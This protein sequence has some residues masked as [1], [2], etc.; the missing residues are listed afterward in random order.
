M[1]TDFGAGIFSFVTFLCR[2]KRPVN[3]N[4]A[5]FGLTDFAMPNVS[6]SIRKREQRYCVVIKLLCIDGMLKTKKNIKKL[7]FVIF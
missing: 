2:K 1:R 4:S 7:L 5:F 6:D 3:V